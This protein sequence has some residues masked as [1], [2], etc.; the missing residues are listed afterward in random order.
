MCNHH[1]NDKHIFEIGMFVHVLSHCVLLMFQS[2]ICLPYDNLKSQFL[3]QYIFWQSQINLYWLLENLGKLGSTV[4]FLT[5]EHISSHAAFVGWNKYVY[6]YH[7]RMKNMIEKIDCCFT[8]FFINKTSTLARFRVVPYSSNNGINLYS[9]QI[10]LAV[11]GRRYGISSKFAGFSFKK[12]GL[13]ASCRVRGRQVHR[14]LILNGFL[15]SVVVQKKIIK[16]CERELRNFCSKWPVGEL[17]HATTTT[18]WWKLGLRS[19][20]NSEKKAAICGCL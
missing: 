3:T 11:V 12:K 20:L 5:I 6:F 7:V 2:Q 14:W 19:A 1:P 16:Q 4:I 9:V 17:R 10:E 8:E 13:P 15:M 18:Q